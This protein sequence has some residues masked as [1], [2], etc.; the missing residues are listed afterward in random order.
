MSGELEGGTKVI[1]TSKWPPPAT[2]ELSKVGKSS[3]LFRVTAAPKSPPMPNC[4]PRHGW[5]KAGTTKTIRWRPRIGP[6]NARY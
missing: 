3:Y 6:E 4:Q 1:R 5:V 2:P